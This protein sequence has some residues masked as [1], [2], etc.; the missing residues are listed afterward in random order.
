MPQTQLAK[1]LSRSPDGL[2]MTLAGDNSLSR[3]LNPAKRR[4]GKRIYFA[5][6]DVA[7]LIDEMDERAAA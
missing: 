5:V 4:I 2:R 3:R 6:L 1:V 7:K